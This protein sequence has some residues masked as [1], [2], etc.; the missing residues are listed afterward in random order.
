MVVRDRQMY[1]SAVG[2]DAENMVAQQWRTQ[3]AEEQRKLLATL[4]EDVAVET[5]VGDGEDWHSALGSLKWKAGEVLAVGSSR[6]GQVAKVF[7][8][9]NS[10]RIIHASAVPVIVVPRGAEAGL[11][12]AAEAEQLAPG[13]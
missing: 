3:A 13:A 11:E 1:P 5:T 9:A 10:T 6:L 4:P 12:S 2:Y 7:L 8:G